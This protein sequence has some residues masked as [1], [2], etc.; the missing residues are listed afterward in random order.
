MSR[1]GD[2]GV[3]CVRVGGASTGWGVFVSVCLCLC[4]CV[5]VLRVHL[6]SALY[7]LRK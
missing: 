1:R 3:F 5:C 7:S 4:A 6:I 2:S